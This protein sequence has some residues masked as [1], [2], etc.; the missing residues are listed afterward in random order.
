M[1]ISIVIVIALS[2]LSEIAFQWCTVYCLICLRYFGCFTSHSWLLRPDGLF[3]DLF[4]RFSDRLFRLLNLVRSICWGL[5]K[6]CIF[7]WVIELVFSTSY[8][9]FLLTLYPPL[10]VFLL[11]KVD[12]FWTDLPLYRY[13]MLSSDRFQPIFSSS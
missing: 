4:G 5:I 13:P 10:P 7:C 12:S 11:I 2:I 1:T 6:F 8:F 3:C 9:M